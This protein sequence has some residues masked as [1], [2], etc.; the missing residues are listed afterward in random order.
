MLCTQAAGMGE[1]LVELRHTRAAQVRNRRPVCCRI[2]NDRYI[3]PQIED[4]E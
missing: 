4:P 3:H 2:F 1:C